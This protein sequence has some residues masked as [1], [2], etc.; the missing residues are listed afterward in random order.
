VFF[1][2]CPPPL[3]HPPSSFSPRSK[4]FPRRATNIFARR[5]RSPAFEEWGCSYPLL[6]VFILLGVFVRAFFSVRF[7]PPALFR[8]P[9]HQL[10]YQSSRLGSFSGLFPP[11]LGIFSS[12]VFPVFTPARSIALSG[13][14]SYWRLLDVFPCGPSR[15]LTLIDYT[16][17]VCFV[18]FCDSGGFFPFFLLVRIVSSRFSPFCVPYFQSYEGGPLFLSERPQLLGL[19]GPAGRRFLLP[20]PMQSF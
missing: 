5:L 3:L 4:S 8:P 7:S 9:A 12:F 10:Y 17:S 14:S 13:S 16:P 19:C 11:L 1:C 2:P 18:F 15:F 20:L 6:E